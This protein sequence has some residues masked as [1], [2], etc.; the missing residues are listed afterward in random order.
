M[1]NKKLLLYFSVGTLVLLGLGFVCVVAR[2][3]GLCKNAEYCSRLFDFGQPLVAGM[4]FVLSMLS[5]QLLLPEIFF[6]VWKYFFIPIF[7]LGV[8]LV[9]TASGSCGWILCENPMQMVSFW[10]FYFVNGSLIVFVVTA[11][12]NYIAI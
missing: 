10:G 12:F 9:L 3:Y 2:E 6:R 7:L 5:I 11:A 8:Y 1:T 4:S